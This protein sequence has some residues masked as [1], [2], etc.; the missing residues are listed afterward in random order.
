MPDFHKRRDGRNQIKIYAVHPH[1]Q[2]NDLRLNRVAQRVLKA[3]GWSFDLK[4]ILAD[5]AE[6]RRLHRLFLGA[7][8]ATDVM[9]FAGD[10]QDS[11]AGEIYISLDQARE[12]ALQEGHT[13]QRAVERLLIHGILHLGGWDDS[14]RAERAKMLA[15]GERYLSAR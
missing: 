11:G 15:Y 9:A 14:T 12:Q 3:E 13:L 1:A 2:A 8:E 5:D 6:L 7:D 10:A 4:I